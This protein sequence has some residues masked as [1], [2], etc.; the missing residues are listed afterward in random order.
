VCSFHLIIIIIARIVVSWRH[1]SR[2]NPIT[3]P[4][5]QIRFIEPNKKFRRHVDGIIRLCISERTLTYQT[6]GGSPGAREGWMDGWP[7]KGG[8]LLLDCGNAWSTFA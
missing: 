7:W 3:F 5:A 1:P 2:R 6:N 8:L 4:Y